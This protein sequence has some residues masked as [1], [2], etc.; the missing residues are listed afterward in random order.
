[1]GEALPCGFIEWQNREAGRWLGNANRHRGLA[2]QF[3][4]LEGGQGL[5]ANRTD[6]PAKLPAGSPPWPG[7]LHSPLVMPALGGRCSHWSDGHLRAQ[8]RV[9]MKSLLWLVVVG[10]AA[11]GA[12]D[13]V[14]GDGQPVTRRGTSVLHY[15]THNDLAA[16]DVAS[17][18]SGS[19]RL[20]FNEQG[21][22][23]KQSFQ[24]RIAGLETNSSYGLTALV[25]D[26]TNAAQVVTLITGRTGRARVSY[27]SRGQG[28]SGRNPLPDGLAP[29]TD[30]RAVG[31]ENGS[32]QTVA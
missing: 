30:V 12:L 27:L 17:N 28:L 16:T 2:K 23:R 8:G 11:S 13:A 10:M 6:R 7:S 32:T 20:Q 19:L 3:P 14:A 4:R 9:M 26:D 25:G 24:L 22:A 31:V 5:V 15:M 21:H 29:L 18:A 1:M